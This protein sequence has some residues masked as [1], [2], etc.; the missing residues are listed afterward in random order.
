MRACENESHAGRT[1]FAYRRLVSM[2]LTQNA[3]PHYDGSALLNELVR[4]YR[5]EAVHS[6]ETLRAPKARE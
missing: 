5:E 3:G 2:L 1:L 4:R 6:A